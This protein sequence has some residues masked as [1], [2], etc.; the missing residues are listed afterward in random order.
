MDSRPIGVPMARVSP[1]VLAARALVRGHEAARYRR[2][3]LPPIKDVYSSC[4][5]ESV[6]AMPGPAVLTAGFA[7]SR[8][9]AFQQPAFKQNSKRRTDTSVSGSRVNLFLQGAFR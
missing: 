7:A 5:T 6:G 2:L 3:F 8:P 1:S 9:A 4:L